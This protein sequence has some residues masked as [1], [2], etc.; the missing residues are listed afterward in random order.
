[1]EKPLQNEHNDCAVV[2]IQSSIPHCHWCRHPKRSAISPGCDLPLWSPSAGVA[3][4]GGWG[5]RCRNRPWKIH[6][7]VSQY[8][9]SYSACY[10][11]STLNCLRCTHLPTL[12]LWGGDHRS[13][14][15]RRRERWP[16]LV[17]INLP[18]TRHHCYT[19]RFTWKK[20]Y[21]YDCLQWGSRGRQVYGLF[22]F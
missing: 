3:V 14:G 6:Y 19:Y 9:A 16:R 10:I 2:L 17:H 1:M 11:C 5:T 13:P 21:I 8:R 7:R 15:C 4:T 12:P 20:K 22:F 18:I